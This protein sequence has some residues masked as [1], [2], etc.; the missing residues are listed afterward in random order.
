MNESVETKRRIPNGTS[1]RA[2]FRGLPYASGCRPR[3]MAAKMCAFEIGIKSVLNSGQCSVGI[4][5]N[6]GAGLLI[7]TVGTNTSVVKRDK[8][9]IENM[10]NLA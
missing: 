9:M 5:L 10:E 1:K 8:R 3:H 4:L 7:G 6:R 2:S